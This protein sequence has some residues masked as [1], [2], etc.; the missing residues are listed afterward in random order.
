MIQWVVYWN[1]LLK[2]CH[3]AGYTRST[4]IL[5]ITFTLQILIILFFSCLEKWAGNKPGQRGCCRS[6]VLYVNYLLL[7][8]CYV[9]L[10]WALFER[11]GYVVVERQPR[12]REVVG[13][14]HALV[15]PNTL[16]TIAMA[17]PPWRSE[18]FGEHYNWLTGIRINWP[19]TYW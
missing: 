6:R 5:F 19:E 12:V 11:L 8:Y 7:R 17:F 3:V 2:K 16:K 4:A 9:L 18:L 10:L 15:K 13:S 14:I 1:R